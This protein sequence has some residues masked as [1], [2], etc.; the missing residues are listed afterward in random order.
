MDEQTDQQLL[1]LAA[2]AVGFIDDETC[3]ESFLDA[4]G[5][6]K[7]WKGLYYVSSAIDFYTWDP[8]AKTTQGRSDCWQIEN[9]LKLNISW[10]RRWVIRRDN[11]FL[12]AQHKNRQRASV[13]AAAVIGRSM[14]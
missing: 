13:M 14:K 10:Q 6:H 8:L 11:G 4:D 5:L 2:L 12:L 9:D 3:E 7:S 1:E